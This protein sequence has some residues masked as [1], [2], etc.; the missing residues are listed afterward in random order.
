MTEKITLKNLPSNLKMKLTDFFFFFT[1]EYF[2]GKLRKIPENYLIK[3]TDDVNVGDR[4]T[5]LCHIKY[6][7]IS[8]KVIIGNTNDFQTAFLNL[9][10]DK[11]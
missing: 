10:L 6:Y 3:A 4:K 2:I 5:Q 9:L 1:L 7:L 11:I 8:D